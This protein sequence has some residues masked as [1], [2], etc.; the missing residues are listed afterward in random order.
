MAAL[1]E[2]GKNVEVKMKGIKLTLKVIGAAA[3]FA[4]RYL[5]AQGTNCT[6]WLTRDPLCVSG[7]YYFCCPDGYYIEQAEG[8]PY[9][10][11]PGGIF[12]TGWYQCI[13]S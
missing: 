8:G 2:S 7:N 5:P 3:L 10:L 11:S 6:L 1:N 4:V 12:N 13:P 9:C